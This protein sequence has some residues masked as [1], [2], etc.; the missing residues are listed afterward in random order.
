MAWYCGGYLL[1]DNTS[2]SGGR[3]LPRCHARLNG[4]S[5]SGSYGGGYGGGNL[6][7][8]K[9]NGL[10]LRGWVSTRLSG[11]GTKGHYTLAR[12]GV[13]Q[14]VAGVAIWQAADEPRGWGE[15]VNV[16]VLG[17]WNPKTCLV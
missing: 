14:V 4:S 15:Q 1:L 7:R 17:G 10:L 11:G 3:Y 2:G 9:L 6:P 12:H 8:N 5:N 16:L 13:G